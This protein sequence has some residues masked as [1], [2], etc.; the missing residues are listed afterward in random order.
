MLLAASEGMYLYDLPP[1]EPT[2]SC[3]PPDTVDLKPIW[4]TYS[5]W[6]TRTPIISPPVTYTDPLP[7]ARCMLWTGKDV[8]DLDFPLGSVTDDSR[9]MLH[10]VHTQYNHASIYLGYSTGVQYPPCSQRIPTPAFSMAFGW[11]CESGHLRLGR[12]GPSVKKARMERAHVAVDG[13]Y[14]E[15]DVSM[16]ELSG[17]ISIL[18]HSTGRLQ[19]YDVA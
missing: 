16:D 10:V 5:R 13:T 3:Q 1:P 9:F 2:F 12:E 7:R 11:G 6:L 18:D 19:L 15:G 17:R 8:F 14:S 4:T